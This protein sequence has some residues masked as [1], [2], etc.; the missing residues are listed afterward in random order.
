[1]LSSLRQLLIL[2]KF[3]FRVCFRVRLLASDTHSGVHKLEIILRVKTVGKQEYIIYKNFTQ[4][5]RGV[6]INYK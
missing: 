1:M 3:S 4:S 6:K 2:V 5:A